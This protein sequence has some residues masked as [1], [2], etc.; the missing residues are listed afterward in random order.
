M[1][2]NR[3]INRK[4]PY[5]LQH[6]YNPVD[7][8]SWGEEA[9][10]KAV[11]EDRPV[12]LSI[13]YSSCHWCHVMERESFEDES[14]AEIMN[15]VFVCIKVDREENPDVDELFMTACNMISGSGGWPLTVFLTPDLVPFFA[16]TY[17]PR[18]SSFGRTGLKDIAGRIHNLWTKNRNAIISS[19]SAVRESINSFYRTNPSEPVGEN[20]FVS[21]DRK[22]K[23]RFDNE[24][25]G[26]L[27]H[28]KF[29]MPHNLVY[30]MK[31][32]RNT[33]DESL[34]EMAL[35][36]LKKMRAGG[37]WD[38]VGHGFHRYS[39]DTKW[40]LPHFEKMLYDQA[41][42]TVAFLEAFDLTGD[43]F[44]RNTA[45]EILDY[46]LSDLTSPEGGFYSAED[47]DSEGEEGLFYTWEYSELQNLLDKN[48]LE[49]LESGYGV[50]PEGNY[51]DEASG[52]NTGRNILS[53]STLVA[54]S[55]HSNAD[56]ENQDYPCTRFGKIR[57]ILLE[58]RRH[59]TRPLLDK[60]IIVSWNGLAIMAFSL[61]FR[62]TGDTAYIDAAVK[63]TD[64]IRKNM[65]SGK[66]RLFRGG[67]DIYNATSSVSQDYSHLITGLICLAEASG[68][69]KYIEWAVELQDIM[70]EDFFDAES[71]IFRMSDK[72]WR[73][74]ANP[75]DIH[76]SAIPSSNSA[77]IFNL[78]RLSDITGRDDWRII[79]EKT[80]KSV[81][82][83]AR[84]WPDGFA[85][86]LA[87]VIKD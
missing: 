16:A 60:K 83:E 41:L 68:I 79:S 42:C 38:H 34:K 15:R 33:G 55:M 27:P 62:H 40:F 81:A 1:K 20:D 13:G 53:A 63:S 36:T 12:F 6:A 80:E 58:K 78:K 77:A 56:S 48:D 47:A 54:Q 51:M 24:E 30:L 75:F 9:F 76:D 10:R 50:L 2:P 26:F 86:F 72:N 73:L 64:F 74:F 4:S 5:L 59:R 45:R 32:Y 14:T 17:I 39:T 67:M 23:S 35:M 28:P 70:I 71:N 43:V 46:V 8:Y 82:G 18:E 3:L 66:G 65:T 84:K 19:A 87:S 69:K 57:N 44:F 37:I 11:D 61:A 49:F 22:M 21:A 7:W 31:R 52:K 29:P 85:W 25:G